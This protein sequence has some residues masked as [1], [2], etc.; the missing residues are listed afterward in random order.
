MQGVKTIPSAK[1]MG[2]QMYNNIMIESVG[3]LT[4]EVRRRVDR[5]KRDAPCAEIALTV[6]ISVEFWIGMQGVKTTQ[7]GKLRMTK[8]IKAS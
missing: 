1:N 8:C 7:S 3:Y 6:R 2:E 5:K 4:F